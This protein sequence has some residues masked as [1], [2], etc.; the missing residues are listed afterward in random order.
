LLLYLLTIPNGL[1]ILEAEGVD[2][3]RKYGCDDVCPFTKCSTGG[4]Q[5]YPVSCA[6]LAFLDRISISIGSSGLVRVRIMNGVCCDV[7]PAVITIAKYELGALAARC[8]LSVRKPG[9]KA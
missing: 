9:G 7:G 4:T 3:R 1:T 5:I 8:K 6:E 2:S